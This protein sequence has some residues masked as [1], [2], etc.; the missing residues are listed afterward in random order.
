MKKKKRGSKDEDGVED[1]EEEE[2]KMSFKF[3]HPPKLFYVY[4]F[5]VREIPASHI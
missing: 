2:S 1:N 3:R 4:F 5:I